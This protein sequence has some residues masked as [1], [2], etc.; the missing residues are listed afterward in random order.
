MAFSARRTVGK[1][2]G[3]LR[4]FWLMMGICLML[5]VVAE[6]CFRA[7][8]SVG[9]SITARR[10]G[11]SAVVDPRTRTDW[12]DDYM[13]DFNATR[14]AK[15]KPFVYFSRHPSYAGRYINID[16]AGRRITPQPSMPM[17]PRARVFFFGGSTM[18]GTSQRDSMTIPAEASRRLQT[19]AG[20]GHRIEVTNF[21][22]NGYVMTQEV[23][24]LMLQLRKGNIPDI[25]VFFDGIND[26]GATVQ[27]G[28]GGNTQNESKR[29]SE[30]A[31]GRKLDRTGADRGIRRDLR[32]LGLLAMTSAEQLEL[33]Q[34]LKTMVPQQPKQF[35]SADS[36]ARSTVA[37]YTANVRLVEAL[38]KEYGFTPIYVWQPTLHTSTKPLTRFEQR[39][40][41][42]IKADPFNSRLREVHLA[43]P[44]M[45][46]SIMPR[47]APGRFV[48][49][50]DLF[51]GDTTHIYV[52]RVGHNTEEAIPTIVKAF[53]PTLQ[54]EVQR[55]FER[56]YATTSAAQCTLERRKSRRRS[57]RPDWGCEARSFVPDAP[58]A[59]SQ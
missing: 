30:F 47:I 3:A 11:S 42:S 16:S 14:A 15:W 32:A 12:Y 17:L 18:W 29:V 51:D 59:S 7:Q 19:I 23:I 5:V 10:S 57:L 38:A 58:S 43:I 50:A 52:D 48:N 25:V 34:K 8:R 37:F 27:W 24:E 41:H 26:A 35:V 33:L 6:A 20:T 49:A 13:V 36:G 55:K 28:H 2:W 40:M 22:E 45:L 54:T 46:D 44:F 56:I 39:L 1:G 9:E 31:L 21:G 4:A 53:W